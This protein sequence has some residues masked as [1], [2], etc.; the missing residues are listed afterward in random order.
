MTKKQL[1]QEIKKG[2]WIFE[3]RQRDENPV[4]LA[5]LLSQAVFYNFS[6]EAGLPIKFDSYIFNDTQCV[7]SKK[8]NKEKILRLIRKEVSRG[9]YLEYVYQKTLKRLG[10]WEKFVTHIEQELKRKN[11][12]KD[13]LSLWNKYCQEAVKLIPWFY[14]PWF[15]IEENMITDK[16]Q[17]GLSRYKKKIIQYTDLKNAL[18][19]L[20]APAQ[21]THYQKEQEDYYQLVFAAKSRENWKKNRE[22]LKAA[23]KYLKDYA[24]MKTFFLLPRQ[25]LSFF[26]LCMRVDQSLDDGFLKEYKKRQ[27]DIQI[28]QKLK[29]LLL[30]ILISD[31]ELTNSIGWASRFS[32]LLTFSVEE[33]FKISAR[34]LPFFKI[35]ARSIKVPYKD[36]IYLT[37]DEINNILDGKKINTVDIIKKRQEGFVFLMYDGQN[38]INAGEDGHKL[39]LFIDKNIRLSKKHS[40]TKEIKGQTAMPG[41]VVGKVRVALRPDDSKKLKLGEILVCSM[42]SPDYLPAMKKS[43]AIITDEGGVLSHAAIV[44]RE[45]KEP[46]VIKTKIATQILKTGDKVEVDANNGIVK[47]IKN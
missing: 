6:Q 8:K 14:I 36:W 37:V 13:F 17:E 18:G 26:E 40:K 7:Y 4:L 43:S 41:K 24:W 21:A 25:P 20:T 11:N 2:E 19:I 32:W 42:T 34:L 10:A 38:Y 9:N 28:D 27:E 30:K 15:I 22:F 44:A 31:K 5:D 45:I 33:A 47:I 23:N 29:N 39:A 12:T 3:F 16:V 35:I 1:I 46:C